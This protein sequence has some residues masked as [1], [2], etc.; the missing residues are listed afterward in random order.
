[1][2]NERFGIE[3]AT[4]QMILVPVMTVL[5]QHLSHGTTTA[6]TLHLITSV[7]FI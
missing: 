1:M 2:Q 5:T 3:L 7:C 6:Q 4:I